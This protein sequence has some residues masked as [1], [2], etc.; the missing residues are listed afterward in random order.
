MIFDAT[1]KII[2]NINHVGI[3]F[4]REITNTICIN[5]KNTL[6]ISTEYRVPT[7]YYQVYIILEYFTIE[8]FENLVTENLPGCLFYS[9][10]W[11]PFDNTT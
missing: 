11:S 2:Y 5:F 8:R 6:A 10:T 7:K 3:Y 4:F 9:T 1:I